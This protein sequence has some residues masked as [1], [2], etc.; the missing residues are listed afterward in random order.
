MLKHCI[1]EMQFI[2]KRPDPLPFVFSPNLS[3]QSASM[4][5]LH[6]MFRGK[7]F[8]LFFRDCS[9]KLGMR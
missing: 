5:S 2:A 7:H 8:S 9:V 6:K 4:F 3:I 1:R